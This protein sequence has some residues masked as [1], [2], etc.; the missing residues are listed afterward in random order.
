M[1]GKLSLVAV[2][3][4]KLS[5]RG[6]LSEIALSPD[7]FERPRRGRYSISSEIEQVGKITGQIYDW[8]AGGGWAK[9]LKLHWKCPECGY[10]DWGD[11]IPGTQ[12]PCLWF[13]NCKCVDK[14]LISYDEQ[15]VNRPK[16]D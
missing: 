5:C 14:W 11:W 6:R 9:H 12:N 13:G 4:W 1:A 7:I 15:P 3:V 8:V 2:T 10:E 16:R